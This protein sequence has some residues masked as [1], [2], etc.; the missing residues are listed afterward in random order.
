MDPR[1]IDL[2]IKEE[3]EKKKLRE[4]A[5]WG[6]RAE[7]YYEYPLEDDEPTTEEAKERVIIIDI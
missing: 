6:E 4:E 5:E 2:L 1:I 7:L 3:E